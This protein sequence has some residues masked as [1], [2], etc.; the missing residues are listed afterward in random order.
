VFVATD[1]NR[2][3]RLNRVAVRR[4]TPR[5]FRCASIRQLKSKLAAKHFAPVVA[6]CAARLRQGVRP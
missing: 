1:L 6:Q 2:G 3:L 5:A 4:T